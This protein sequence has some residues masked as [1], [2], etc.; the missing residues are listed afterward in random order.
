MQALH[1]RGRRRRDSK[2]IAAQVK[3]ASGREEELAQEIRQLVSGMEGASKAVAAA[4]AAPALAH[5]QVGNTG[6]RRT[7]M[8]NTA[9]D[10]VGKI[11]VAAQKAMTSG[12][13]L[14][15][16]T[17]DEEVT[18]RLGSSNKNTDASAPNGTTSEGEDLAHMLIM[19]C[20]HGTGDNACG[21]T[22]GDKCP[23][24]NRVH[25]D[26]NRLVAVRSNKWTSIKDQRNRR[27]GTGISIRKKLGHRPRTLPGQNQQK[28]DNNDTVTP[29][30]SGRHHGRR[31]QA[32]C[33]KSRRHANTVH[34]TKGHDQR[35]QRKQRCTC[36]HLLRR[37]R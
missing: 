6:G 1:G 30:A 19:L 2:R 26:Q 12:I 37:N 23:C 14:T 22:R 36:V 16:E 20:N 3:E 24:V 13:N 18:K 5:D 11:D 15:A 21:G 33:W 35:M 8:T 32:G 7:A 27:R 29:T 31:S 9:E 28:R 4:L 10:L 17:K 34:R 25:K